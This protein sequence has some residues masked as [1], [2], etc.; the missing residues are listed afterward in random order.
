[1]VWGMI[2][3]N[4]RSQ[5]V[6]IE[7][8]LNAQRYANEILRPH[9]LPLLAAQR[10]VFQQDNA[11]SHCARLTTQFLTANN[12]LTLPWPSLC[13][14]VWFTQHQCKGVGEVDGLLTNI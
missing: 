5:L 14:C 4:G 2:S 9:V 6:H 13:T 8:G 1:M 3:Y 12:I 7:G 11:R 10:S